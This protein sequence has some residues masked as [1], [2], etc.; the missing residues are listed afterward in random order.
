MTT[1]KKRKKVCFLRAEDIFPVKFARLEKLPSQSL[2][3]CNCILFQYIF[4]IFRAWLTIARMAVCLR[5]ED[6]QRAV[7]T[8]QSV[9]HH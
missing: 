9:R 6:L 8:F 7:H 4:Q 5:A 3:V 1:S 2:H